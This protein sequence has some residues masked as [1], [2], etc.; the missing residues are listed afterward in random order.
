MIKYI[1]KDEPL[2]FVNSKNAN[3][4]VIGEAL[5][6]I[7]EANDGRLKPLAVV[8]EA[9]NVKHPL[10]PYFEWDDQVAATSYRMEQARTL[11]RVIRVETGGSEPVRAFLSISDKG[12]VSYRTLGEV[13]G[14]LDLQLL[15]LDKAEKDLLA[16]ET[17]YKNL[18]EICDIVRA[19]R[20]RV[21][22]RKNK[23]ESRVT[24]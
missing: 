17:R 20:E 10:H 5:E 2:V 7:A 13:Q 22:A 15:I 8:D 3:P 24:N 9:R 12:G 1:F 11:I 6:Q 18:I 21:A 16:F 4:Q 14:S 23:H 19:A